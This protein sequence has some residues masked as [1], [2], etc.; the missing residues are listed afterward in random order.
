MGISYEID[1]ELKEICSN[2]S[3]LLFPH[4]Q[5]DSVVC[6]RS[7]G[8]STRNTLARCHALGKAMQIALGRK[9][10]YVIEVISEKFDKLPEDEKLKT[11]IHELMHIPKTFGGGFIFHDVVN[12]KNVDRMYDKYIFLRNQEN[13]KR[14]LF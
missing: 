12:R 2:I 11:L 8:S 3:Q 5:L 10:F 9:G 14:F 6:L 13:E 7:F 1:D 4:V